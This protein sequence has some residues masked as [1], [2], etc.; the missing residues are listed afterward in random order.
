MY[1]NSLI[2]IEAILGGRVEFREDENTYTELL[3][4]HLCFHLFVTPPMPAE[5]IEAVLEYDPDYL[6]VLY[7][8]VSA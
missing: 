2:A 6:S 7:S 8:A 1:M 5:V 3:N 4:G